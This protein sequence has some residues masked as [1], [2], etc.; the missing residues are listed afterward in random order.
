ML[1]GR[2][3][4]TVFLAIGLWQHGS[5]FALSP[6][7]D[8]SQYA[9]TAWRISEGLIGSAVLAIA[10]TPDGYLWLGTDSGLLR[11]DGVRASPWQPP[12]GERLPGAD[13]TKL[14]VA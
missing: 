3:R 10:Q 13:I 2:L 7:L 4:A 6:A 9:R 12:R 1:T 11:F 14:L 8:I 5:A